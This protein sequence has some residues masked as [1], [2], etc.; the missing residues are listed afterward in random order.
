MLRAPL[1]PVTP[2]VPA[3]PGAPVAAAATATAV[4]LNNITIAP[5]SA[6]ITRPSLHL[7]IPATP[8]DQNLHFSQSSSLPSTPSRARNRLNGIHTARQHAN[9]DTWVKNLSPRRGRPYG[10]HEK[11][12]RRSAMWHLTD[13][14]EDKMEKMMSMCSVPSVFVNYQETGFKV[15]TF[16]KTIEIYP[17]SSE[18]GMQLI[19]A[20]LGLGVNKGS[21]TIHDH[22][23]V[24][25]RELVDLTPELLKSMM[26]VEDTQVSFFPPLVLLRDK[27]S[28]MDRESFNRFCR[29]KSGM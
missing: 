5:A 13:H 17:D 26:H 20:Y 8:E 25:P 2:A 21:L 19:N 3:V 22:E 23:T 28:G 16:P 27:F 4:S 29:Q 15:S 10:L 18:L 11:D 12:Q 7:N 6:A 9:I 14:I 1:L 24:M